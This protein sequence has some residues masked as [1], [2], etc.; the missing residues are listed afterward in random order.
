MDLALPSLGLGAGPLGDGVVDE[1][2]ARAVVHAAL[3][4]GLGFFDTARSYGASEERLGRLLEGRKD[5]LVA[6]KG[7]YGVDGVADWTPDVV[8]LGI[9]RALGI[10][11]RETLDVFFLHS[12]PRETL[13]NT[14][15]I[16][17]LDRALRAGKIRARGYSGDGD[18]LA[19]AVASGRFDVVECSV[20][21][22]DRANLAVAGK[23]PLVAKRALMNAAFA[24]RDRPTREDVAVYWD[25]LRARPLDPSPLSWPELALRFAAHAP[26]VTCTLVG[27]TRPENVASARQAY[28]RGA[29]DA[30]M[31]ARL[32]GSWDPAWTA[33]V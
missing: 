14:A 30:G 27:T 15:I 28:D 26:G 4:H 33:L 16:D 6:T 1:D 11:R 10:L 20:N 8:R 13:Q 29:L 18:A 21:V 22:V 19:F 3:D 17:E 32:E 12:C 9:D 7:G 25:R 5:V 2:R 23:I 24:H 31:L